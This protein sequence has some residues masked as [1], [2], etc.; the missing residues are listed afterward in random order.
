MKD[1]DKGCAKLK[2]QMVQLAE[3]L[4][5]QGPVESKDV[6]GPDSWRSGIV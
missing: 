4:A 5:D 6:L 3:Q 2:H 1:E